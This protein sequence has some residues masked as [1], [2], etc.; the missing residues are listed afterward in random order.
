MTLFKK[1]PLIKSVVF[2]LTAITPTGLVFAAC[3][4]ADANLYN[5]WG[6]NPVDMVSCPPLP[7]PNDSCDYS[8]ADS[9]GGWGW[10][11]TTQM[12]CRPLAPVASE[13][14]D[15]DGDGWGWNGIASCLIGEEPT[16]NDHLILIDNPGATLYSY[17]RTPDDAA[18]Y[19]QY[20]GA[21]LHSG[22]SGRYSD[23]FMRDN[24]TGAI[25]VLSVGENN[26]EANNDSY[27]SGISEDG[28]TVLL[29]SRATNFTGTIAN[30]VEQLYLLDIP[31][32]S[33]T[34]VVNTVRG[35]SP[36]SY[37]RGLLSKDGNYVAFSTEA[38]NI[39]DGDNNSTS[40]IFIFDIANSLTTR[41]T[42]N[43]YGEEANDTSYL[44][45]IS[46]D[47]RYVLFVSRADNLLS[48]AEFSSGLYVYDRLNQTNTLVRRIDD[49][50]QAT[51]SDDGSI[52]AFEYRRSTGMTLAWINLLTGEVGSID[53]ASE[54]YSSS[55][56]V[57]PDGRFVAY[58]STKTDLVNDVIVSG[59]Q[60][61]LYLTELATGNTT[62][63][64]QSPDGR[65]ANNGVYSAEFIAGGKYLR[66]NSSASNLHSEDNNTNYDTFLYE[67]PQ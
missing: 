13:C 56:E 4:Y 66:F 45:D 54:G 26:F 23:V 53:T 52:V 47:G 17:Q 36:W 48:T 31:T 35:T 16:L 30:G 28:N 55:P 1:S 67:I 39:V 6:W 62:L 64:S 8:D 27:L 57:S 21:D 22:D 34:Q 19:F 14:I 42:A 5:D 32:G 25:N 29:A 58:S 12:S 60:S 61:L 11:A 49:L 51:L 18:S 24:N 3:E 20:W 59:D 38:A 63:V 7:D 65:E 33:F 9:Y 10:N 15:S 50:N 40:D 43:P 37:V 2:A 46:A 44:R 41:I